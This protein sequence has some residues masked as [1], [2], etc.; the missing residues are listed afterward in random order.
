M[1]LYELNSVGA[2]YDGYRRE[3]DDKT[4]LSLRDTRKTPRLTLAQINKLR[5]ANDVRKFEHEKK[6]ETV[7]KQ[8]A[9]PAAPAGGAPVGV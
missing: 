2:N 5:I 7:T 8:Y 6:L 9:T 1:N 3:K 4:V